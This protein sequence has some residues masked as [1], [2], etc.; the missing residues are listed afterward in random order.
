MTTQGSITPVP[1]P[2]HCGIA[3]L[4]QSPQLADA[5]AACLPHDASGDPEVLARFVFASQPSWARALMRARDLIVAGLGLKTSA[6]LIGTPR[7]AHIPRVGIFRIYSANDTE[8]IL[9]EDDK[10]L[11]FRIS[12]TCAAGPAP[13]SKRMLTIATVVHC[14]NLLGR[15][16]ILAIAPFHRMVVKGCLRRAAL[17]GWP[18]AEDRTPARSGHTTGR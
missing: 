17:R 6:Q 13:D 11:D 18:R 10:H 4:Y 8:I 7:E 16:Y 5:F 1:F 12:L 9:G 3:K 14:H 2:A 15:A